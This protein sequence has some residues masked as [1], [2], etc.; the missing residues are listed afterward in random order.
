MWSCCWEHSS[1]RTGNVEGPRPLYVLALH[2]S[3]ELLELFHCLV[4]DVRVWDLQMDAVCGPAEFSREHVCQDPS[5]H[6]NQ[7]KINRMVDRFM[8]IIAWIFNIVLNIVTAGTNLDHN[9]FLFF[10]FPVRP[11]LPKAKVDLKGWGVQRFTFLK[12]DQSCG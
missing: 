3:L 5:Y 7:L 4:L 8:K 1:C 6:W 9:E 11:V 10:G 12:Q 2:E